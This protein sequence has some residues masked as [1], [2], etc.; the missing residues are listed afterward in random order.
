MRGA[1]RGVGTGTGK[2]TILDRVSGAWALSLAL[3]AQ[4]GAVDAGETK[5]LT[6]PT[7]PPW[8]TEEVR[9]W[10]GWQ[11]VIADLTSLG[12]MM[13]GR[14]LDS[15]AAFSAGALTMTLAVPVIHGLHGRGI[16]MIQSY[17][18]RIGG[19]LLGALIGSQG[20]RS[21]SGLTAGLVVGAVLAVLIDD[22]LLAYEVVGLRG[23]QPLVEVGPEQSQ[24]GI[25]WSF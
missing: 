13:V 22:L 5:A 4:A 20:G 1:N 14:G 9:A 11:L 8:Q 12:V 24:A 19:P 2:W 15:P 25:S 10:Y 3:L 18:L 16:G 23:L 21:D 6:P 17:T 7:A